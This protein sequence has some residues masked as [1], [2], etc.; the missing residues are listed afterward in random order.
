MILRAFLYTTSFKT[1]NL[2]GRAFPPPTR[3]DA[4][5]VLQALYAIPA[6]VA[7]TGRVPRNSDDTRAELHK[8]AV[9][10]ARRRALTTLLAQQVEAERRIVPSAERLGCL[11]I[12]LDQREH[13]DLH[14]LI[15]NR[16]ANDVHI[17][18]FAGCS[19]RLVGDVC[20]VDLFADKLQAV[21][22]KAKVL[23]RRLSHAIREVIRGLAAPCA[24]RT[25]K[26]LLHGRNGERNEAMPSEIGKGCAKGCC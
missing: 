23:K 7:S 4:E 17:D 15:E 26:V 2:A 21:T 24:T 12:D 19:F 6:L 3:L 18:G 8:A 1:R 10:S 16:R 11:D 14:K 25:R 5:A 20:E 9:G 13:G 22:T